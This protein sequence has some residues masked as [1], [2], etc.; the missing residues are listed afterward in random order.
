MRLLSTVES[1]YVERTHR[2]VAYSAK[3]MF[4]ELECVVCVLL[5]Y[6]EDLN[7]VSNDSLLPR[8]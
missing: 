1:Q 3:E 5:D 7:A 2:G 6:L 4:L 8:T